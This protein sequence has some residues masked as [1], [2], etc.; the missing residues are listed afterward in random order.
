MDF[1][2]EIQFKK[3]VEFIFGR[4]NGDQS[5]GKL[6]YFGF[7]RVV[8]RGEDVVEKKKFYN[9]VQKFF[10]SYWEIFVLYVYK[11]KL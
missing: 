7:G 11:E 8:I 5:L 4:E 6:Q 1:F 3:K 9:F 2:R 10:L